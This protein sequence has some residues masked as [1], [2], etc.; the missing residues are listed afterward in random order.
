MK[1]IIFA[2]TLF[3]VPIANASESIEARCAKQAEE[4]NLVYP[5][6]FSIVVD[7]R[8][9]SSPSF[10]RA[11]SLLTG[12]S[13][14]VI[15]WDI[16]EE[17]EIRAFVTWP[18]GISPPEAKASLQALGEINGVSALCVSRSIRF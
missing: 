8:E 15:E 1:S 10:N 5:D 17:N 3:L 9:I 11:M 12:E 6:I 16:R 2:I 14:Q 13:L 4:T 7:V 18:K